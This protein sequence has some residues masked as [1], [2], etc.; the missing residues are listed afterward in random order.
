MNMSYPLWIVSLFN[1]DELEY[2]E[3]KKTDIGGFIQVGILSSFRSWH[4]PKFC[5]DAVWAS[6]ILPVTFPPKN[7]WGLMQFQV[8]QLRKKCGTLHYFY[9]SYNSI[10]WLVNNFD[11]LFVISAIDFSGQYKRIYDYDFCPW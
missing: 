1:L 4:S 2:E 8:C 3:G 6:E 11:V 9:Q 5:S 10:K 7:W